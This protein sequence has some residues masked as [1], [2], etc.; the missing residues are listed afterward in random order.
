[1]AVRSAG[2]ALSACVFAG[3]VLGG[4]AVAVPVYDIPT[5]SPPPPVA[6]PAPAAEVDSA[7]PAPPAGLAELPDPVVQPVPKSKRGNRPYTVWG[8]RYDVLASASGY[9]EVGRAS[10]YG[11]KFNGRETSSGEIYDMF[12]LTA[13]HRSL[14][15]PTYVRVTNLDNGKHSIVRVND[16]GPFH[17]DR[18]I[19]LSYAAAVKLGFED[20]GT[21]RVRVQA[22]T[23]PPTP[24]TADSP[25][26]VR[27]G[28]FAQFAKAV[29]A[30]DEL[31]PLI[32]AETYVVRTDAAFSVRIG[33]LASRTELERLK[34]I[35]VF[36]ERAPVIIEE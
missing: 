8:E 20:Q 6:G 5:P 21:A 27:A 32:P 11:V 22:V 25:Y 34:A 4:C 24:A 1:M 26:F 3:C 19:D 31:S 30:A 29:A 15:I 35:L 12:Q 13:A 33:P 2:G 28:S 7:P 23:V 18:I 10:W 36:Q 9:D 14:P 16:R 17:P